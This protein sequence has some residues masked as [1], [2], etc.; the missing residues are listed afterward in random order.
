[1]ASITNLLPAE[2]IV[3]RD[4]RTTHMPAKNLVTGDIV[5]VSL[6]NKLPADVRFI[7]VSS[8]FRVDRSV[9]TGESEPVAGTVDGTDENFLE[10][11][12]IGL[13]GTLC[14]AGS[15]TG[16]LKGVFTVSAVAHAQVSSFRLATTPCSAASPSSHQRARRA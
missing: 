11:K 12:N 3:L 7:E 4:G 8:D 9:L 10:T 1:M 16:E 5:Q 15:A 13:Q 14:V 6:G 2:V